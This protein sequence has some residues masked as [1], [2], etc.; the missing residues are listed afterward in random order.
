MGIYPKRLKSHSYNL[1]VRGVNFVKKL[2]KT[3]SK[4]E[5]RSICSAR[6][7][8]LS[9]KRNRHLFFSFYRLGIRQRVGSE[10][11]KIVEF[12]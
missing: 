7:V 4:F 1:R 8:L 10:G 9:G 11:P 12:Y 3:P 5:L 2:D 6:D